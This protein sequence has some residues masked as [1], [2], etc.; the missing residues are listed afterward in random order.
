MN[1]RRNLPFLGHLLAPGGV[2]FAIG[3]TTVIPA[4]FTAAER[5]QI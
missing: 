2:S 1:E 5:L 3:A 4:L